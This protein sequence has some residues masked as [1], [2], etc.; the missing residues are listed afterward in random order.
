ML[1]NDAFK[2]INGVS[3][4]APSCS[5]FRTDHS[6]ASSRP[7]AF[8]IN[9]LCRVVSKTGKL[10]AAICQIPCTAPNSNVK[11][12]S[13]SE[14]SDLKVKPCAVARSM[15]LFSGMASKLNTPF[16]MTIFIYLFISLLHRT[17][18]R[19]AILKG[20]GELYVEKSFSVCVTVHVL[21]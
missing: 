10:H 15:E 19:K 5:W 12:T 9:R 16:S 18:Q 8:F 4:H 14:R 7:Y 11:G 1:K 20:E 21:L 2:S 6:Y 17:S 13:E 3:C